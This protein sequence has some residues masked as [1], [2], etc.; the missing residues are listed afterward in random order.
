MAG[1]TLDT[2][3]AL[4]AARELGA[5]GWA[6][7]ELLL[8]LRAGMAAGSVAQQDGAATRDQNIGGPP[9]LGT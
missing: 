8:A 5:V 6:A 2:A 9:S 3:G 1:L 4:A 7:A